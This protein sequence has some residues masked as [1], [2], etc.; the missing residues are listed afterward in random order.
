MLVAT[1]ANNPSISALLRKS[2]ITEGGAAGAG[3]DWSPGTLEHGKVLQAVC[4]S[5]LARCSV[6]GAMASERRCVGWRC[7]DGQKPM[8]PARD[9]EAVRGRG[10][11]AVLRSVAAANSPGHVHPEACCIGFAKARSSSDITQQ[12]RVSIVDSNAPPDAAQR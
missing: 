7:V 12:I 9:G 3:V 2:W 1:R 10:V 6:F 4:D 5:H 11:P 8:D